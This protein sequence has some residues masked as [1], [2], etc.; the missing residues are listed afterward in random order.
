MI[1]SDIVSTSQHKEEHQTHSHQKTTTLTPTGEKETMKDKATQYDWE[2]DGTDEGSEHMGD[3]S[4][5][6]TKEDGGDSGLETH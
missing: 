2:Q 1:F 5:S 3:R 4:L 6:E